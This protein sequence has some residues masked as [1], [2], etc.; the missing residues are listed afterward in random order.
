MTSRAYLLVRL[1]LVVLLVMLTLLLRAVPSATAD[2]ALPDPPPQ[3]ALPFPPVQITAKSAIVLDGETGQLIYGL[4]PHERRAPASITKIATAIVALQHDSPSRVVTVH[5]S[6]WDLTDSTVMGLFRGERLSIEDLLYGLMLPSGNDAAVAL[7]YAVAGTPTHFVDLMNAT[8]SE[9]GLRNTHFVNPHGLDAPGHY[10]SAYDMAMLA[11]YAMSNE[12]FARIVATKQI[13]L[14]GR[15]VYPLRNTNRFVWHYP[16]ADGVKNGYTTDA[17]QTLVG[18]VTRNGRQI[19]VVVL[20]SDDYV[21]DATTLA[22]YYYDNDAKRPMPI[23]IGQGGELTTAIHQP[24]PDGLV[25]R[26]LDLSGSP[27]GQVP[28]YL[29]RQ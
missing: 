18:S 15:G 28:P 1:A 21:A 8:A 24:S 2:D 26:W 23:R 25:H 7:G 17:R 12:D 6:W 11:R 14:R 4:N 10:T 16:G 27:T 9:L 20:G 3:P 5:V 22:N 13:E 19:F 29:R